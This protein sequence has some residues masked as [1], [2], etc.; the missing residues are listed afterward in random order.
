MRLAAADEDRSCAI[1]VTGGAAT[2][3]VAELLARP[4]HVAALT[5]AAGGAATVLKLPSHDPVEDIGA[6]FDPEH[7]IGQLDVSLGS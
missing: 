1:A 5:S 6:R 4:G 2:L 3:L 7:G